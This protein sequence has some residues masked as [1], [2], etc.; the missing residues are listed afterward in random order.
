VFARRRRSQLLEIARRPSRAPYPRSFSDE[1]PR[2]RRL[3]GGREVGLA[4]RDIDAVEPRAVLPFDRA[5]ASARTCDVAWPDDECAGLI[6]IVWPLTNPPGHAVVLS[7]D[8]AAHPP[9]RLLDR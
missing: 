3:A 9:R 1:G 4:Y 5:P 7:I 6:G 2:V 8:P